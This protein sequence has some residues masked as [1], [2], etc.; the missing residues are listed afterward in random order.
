MLA[1]NAPASIRSGA[2]PKLA[3]QGVVAGAVPWV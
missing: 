3:D 1:A 2:S